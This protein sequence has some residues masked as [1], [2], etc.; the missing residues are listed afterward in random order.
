MTERLA[1]LSIFG[2]IDDAV[3]AEPVR[4]RAVSP[5]LIAY[6]KPEAVGWF[7]E[8]KRWRDPESEEPLPDLEDALVELSR[9]GATTPRMAA[10]RIFALAILLHVVRRHD[11]AVGVP[12]EELTAAVDAVLAVP[13]IEPDGGVPSDA[14]ASEV[15]LTPGHFDHVGDWSTLIDAL[16]DDGVIA[17]HLRLQRVSAPCEQKSVVGP[18]GQSIDIRTRFAVPITF[19]AATGF[20]D[21]SVW[22]DCGD[23]WVEMVDLGEVP[24]SNGNSLYKEVFSL[25]PAYPSPAWSITAHLEFAKRTWPGG[26]R[27]SYR[28]SPD[29]SREPA[30]DVLVD[31]G[32]LVVHELAGGSQVEVDAVKRV[33]FRH[34]FPAEQL[35]VVSCVLG[36][37]EEAQQLV[38]G[39]ADLD[40]DE[41]FEFAPDVETTHAQTVVGPGGSGGAGGAGGGADGDTDLGAAVDEVASA[42]AEVVDACAT[43][44]KDAYAAA[45]SESFGADD[46][47]RITARM[48][49]HWLGAGGTLATAA[50]R[51]NE[52]LAPRR[53]R[54]GRGDDGRRL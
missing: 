42:T 39:C 3:A 36:Y 15:I 50:L 8:L 34:S 44:Y 40:S 43:S 6:E 32:A 30:D 41:G 5:Y 4:A 19:K 20:L 53:A 54:Q 38:L 22:P 26:A 16:V 2:A 18:D 27:V 51:A 12:L 46:A 21:P 49:R 7:P 10:R 11:D 28:L 45:G 52:H 24:N 1:L 33:R 31:E 35:A 23:W 17:G 48:C 25:V 14:S 13:G 37:A 9:T 47:V 29:E